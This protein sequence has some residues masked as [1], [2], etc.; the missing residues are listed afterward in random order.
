MTSATLSLAIANGPSKWVWMIQRLGG[1]IQ[2][3][4]HRTSETPSRGL[5]GFD[6]PIKRPQLCSM[7]SRTVELKKL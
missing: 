5:T 6:R 7:E 2:V 1:Q 4:K 3:V